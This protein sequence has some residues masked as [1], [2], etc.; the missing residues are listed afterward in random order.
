MT[1]DKA[2]VK[3]IVTVEL[4]QNGRIIQ[5]KQQKNLVT[6]EGR[7]ILAKR[8]FGDLTQ[9]I[10]HI[11]LGDG[12]A[13]A[14]VSDQLLDNELTRGAISTFDRTNNQLIYFTTFAEGVGTGTIRE[15]GLFANNGSLVCRSVLQ[16][17][18]FK[19]N[20]SFLNIRWRLQIG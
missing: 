15:V 10:S 1:I 13:P 4:G 2:I 3:G 5:S 18:F 6:T 19:T 7:I 9:S 14:T 20:I 16:T 8:I 11:A 17:E 12:N